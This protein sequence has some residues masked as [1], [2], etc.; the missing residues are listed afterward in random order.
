MPKLKRLSG[1]QVIGIFAKF[2]FVVLSQRG[3]HVKLRR[4]DREGK[5]QSLTIPNHRE[6]DLGTLRA[7]IRQAA[8]FIPENELL[9]H[10]LSD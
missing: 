7:I 3:S 4:L 10:F 6:I 8:R 9:T 1:E 5:Q 2:G